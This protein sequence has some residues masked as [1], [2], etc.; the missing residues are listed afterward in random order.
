MSQPQDCVVAQ[1]LYAAATDDAH[2]WTRVHERF[3]W[4]HRADLA[5]LGARRFPVATRINDLMAQVHGQSH[6]L[7]STEG[8]T[9]FDLMSASEERAFAELAAELA[10]MFS[11]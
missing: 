3:L 8:P 7:V 10:H 1:E 2:P 4:H 5:Q 6:G 9:L 11:D